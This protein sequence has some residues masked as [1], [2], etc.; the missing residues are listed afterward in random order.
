MSG[1]NYANYAWAIKATA[2]NLEIL[3]I[4]KKLL[5]D[6]F[7][8]GLRIRNLDKTWDSLDAM[9]LFEE[10]ADIGADLTINIDGN[11]IVINMLYLSSDHD[12]GNGEAGAYIEFKEEDLYDYTPKVLH[13]ALLDKNIQVPKVDWVT[14]G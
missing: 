9:E 4:T 7:R 3:G 2:E 8:R 10:I 1:R 6:V 14:Y 11:D 13:R 12:I 5:N